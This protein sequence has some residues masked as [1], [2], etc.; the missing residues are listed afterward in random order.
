[1]PLISVNSTIMGSTL[2]SVGAEPPVDGTP[3]G[4]D[5]ADAVGTA[6]VEVAVTE[7]SIV[8]VVVPATDV[9]EPGTVVD[10]AMA[11]GVSLVAVLVATAVGDSRT[12]VAVIDGVPVVSGV[13][14]PG[15][16]VVVGD[17]EIAVDVPKTL[18]DVALGDP[19]IEVAV[20]VPSV[21]VSSQ[22]ARSPAH[23]VIINAA[24]MLFFARIEVCV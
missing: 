9:G 6:D 4:D 24:A 18:A 15:I 17:P 20:A 19:E 12:D 1:M 3:T 22:A 2:V 16:T 13:D 5:V 7:G 10:V 21:A 14:V 8:G 11:V 23:I